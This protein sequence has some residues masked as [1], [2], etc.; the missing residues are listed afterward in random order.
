M[1]DDVGGHSSPI[2]RV[3][4]RLVHATLLEAWVPAYDI[5]HVIIADGDVLWD[6]RRK[7]IFELFAADLVRLS[8]VD[9]RDIREILEKLSPSEPT[10]VLYSSLRGFIR[11]L[12]RGL[13]AGHLQLGHWPQSSSRQ[14]IHPAVYIGSDELDCIR[15]LESQEV[16]VWVQ[17]LPTDRP[18][19]LGCDADY[20]PYLSFI[21]D[22]DSNRP[23]WCDVE[24]LEKFVGQ[25]ARDISSPIVDDTAQRLISEDIHIDFKPGEQISETIIDVELEVVNEKGLHLRAAHALAQLAA[26]YQSSIS[27]GFQDAWVNAKSLLGLTALGAA[28]GTTLRCRIEGVD[29][30]EAAVALKLLFESGFQENDP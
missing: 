1:G 8:V 19:L 16:K 24:C 10:I 14:P 4:P 9:E 6:T 20:K 17:P 12:T 2:H 23:D 13:K 3:D 28:C 5:S 7:T 11:A 18:A 25:Q 29:A 30:Q 21:D 26:R 15:R 22:D 27:V